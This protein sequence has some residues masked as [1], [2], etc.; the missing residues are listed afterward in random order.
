MRQ[1]GERQH[2]T[3]W[4]STSSSGR[5]TPITTVLFCQHGWSDTHHTME[6][7]GHAVASP[8]YQVVAT[9]LG[10]VATWLGID[11]LTDTVEREAVE[12]LG[13]CPDANA[14]VIGH[15]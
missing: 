9:E 10:Y 3:S 11:K 2:G 12:W 7:L 13:R 14:R 1:N 5:S 8:A 4:T 6:R 15:S